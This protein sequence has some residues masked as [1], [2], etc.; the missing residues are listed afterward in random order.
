MGHVV[1]AVA[2]T[3]TDEHGCVLVK[4]L[5]DAEMSWNFFFSI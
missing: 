1:S 3:E 2:N 5:M 4:H